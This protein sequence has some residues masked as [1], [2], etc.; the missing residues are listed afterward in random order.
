MSPGEILL[1]HSSW[2]HTH[3]PVSH[4]MW[5]PLDDCWVFLHEQGTAMLLLHTSFYSVSFVLLQGGNTAHWD[6][7]PLQISLMIHLFD[8]EHND[9]LHKM[10]VNHGAFTA[11]QCATC[12]RS[13]LVWT[14]FNGLSCSWLPKHSCTWCKPCPLVGLSA[15]SPH[16]HF[17]SQVAI[18]PVQVFLWILLGSHK[19][20]LTMVSAAHTHKKNGW[21]WLVNDPAV[22]PAWEWKWKWPLPSAFFLTRSKHHNPHLVFKT[23]KRRKTKK[24]NNGNLKQEDV[25]QSCQTSQTHILGEDDVTA[26]RAVIACRFSKPSKQVRSQSS[27]PAAGV[28]PTQWNTPKRMFPS[29]VTTTRNTS[30]LSMKMSKPLMLLWHL[31]TIKN[32]Q[33]EA[34]TVATATPVDCIVKAH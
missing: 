4:I 31:E 9:W 34:L 22:F 1:G 3:T 12:W 25:N 29:K 32:S 27:S 15:E 2:T 13:R 24:K 11:P 33:Q 18:V 16:D 17:L 7:L 28:H 26:S 5:V 8:E 30:N 21:F 23:A 10:I 20:T 6:Y 14:H 19:M